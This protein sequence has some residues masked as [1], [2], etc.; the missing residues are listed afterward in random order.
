MTAMEALSHPWM[1]LTEEDKNDVNV[2]LIEEMGLM[3]KKRKKPRVV[4]RATY[5]RSDSNS[6]VGQIAK[7]LQSAHIQSERKRSKNAREEE[8]TGV[9]TRSQKRRMIG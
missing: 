8:S 6:S 5:E 9:V 4:V 2:S 7:K 1:Q 3:D